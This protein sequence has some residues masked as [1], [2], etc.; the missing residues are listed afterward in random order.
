VLLSTALLPAAFSALACSALA[1]SSQTSGSGA[2]SAS[3]AA[4]PQKAPPIEATLFPAGKSVL[5]DLPAMKLVPKSAPVVLAAR[6]PAGAVAKLAALSGFSDAEEPLAKE[7]DAAA[8]DISKDLP[9]IAALAQNGVDLAK[10]A[11]VVWMDHDLDTAAIFASVSDEAAMR[12]WLEERAK[13]AKGKRE[14]MT[15]DDALVLRAKRDVTRAVVLRKGHVFFV[16][17]RERSQLDA[18]RVI[19][20]ADALAKTAEAD[21]VGADTTFTKAMQALA[22]GSQAALY[23]NVARFAESLVDARGRALAAAQKQLEEAKA[24]LAD[25]ES[26][27]RKSAVDEARYAAETA[28]HTQRHAEAAAKKAEVLGLLK[29]E[30]PSLAAGVDLGEREVKLKGFLAIAKPGGLKLFAPAGAPSA[31]FDAALHPRAA[32]QLALDP[33]LF[34]A[35]LDHFHQTSLT[36]RTLPI[37]PA[38]GVLASL[39]VD[40]KELDPLLDGE[41]SAASFPQKVAA[42]EAQDAGAGDDAG[43]DAGAPAS[44]EREGFTVIWHVS[45]AARATAVLEAGW[46]TVEGTERAAKGQA[47]RLA[48]GSYEVARGGDMVARVLVAGGSLVVTTQDSPSDLVDPAKPHPPWMAASDHPFLKQLAAIEGASGVVAFDGA[49]WAPR[50]ASLFGDSLK[51]D[52]LR[53]LG[54]VGLL[55]AGSDKGKKLREQRDK[56][57]KQRDELEKQL[58]LHK[59]A[60]WK[61]F[62]ARLGSTVLY[63]KPADGGVAIYGALATPEASLSAL[64]EAAIAAWMSTGPKWEKW[65]E[66]TDLR[67]KI[68]DID[69]AIDADRESAFKGVLG[70]EL[71]AP[72]GA[73]FGRPGGRGSMFDDDVGSL[74]GD[75]P[76]L[77]SLEGGGD[78]RPGRGGGSGAVRPGGAP[79]KK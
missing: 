22:F 30:V 10:P 13:Q 35:V 3:S 36:W 47:K 58:D 21:S 52:A 31:V 37:E 24:A 33:R 5:A 49:L 25:A 20:A 4:A 16:R 41:L 61:S 48:P 74:L 64:A 65:G 45:D 77:K 18:D 68:R 7:I 39:N 59:D 42:P 38:R 50:S 53:D 60:T 8:K 26:K 17:T 15:V 66:L 75:K 76:G 67:K 6:D 57:A 54:L 69:D 40:R 28:E 62:G 73:G 9:E 14:L 11:G 34:D 27:K 44:R 70:D 32:V 29:D 78:V 19:R 79:P 43:A 51:L 1:C 23:V 46:K 72:L 63:A 12:R 71:T 56:L 55:G 2:P